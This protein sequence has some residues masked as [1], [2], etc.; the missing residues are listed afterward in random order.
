MWVHHYL[1]TIYK[2]D[3]NND[4]AILFLYHLK[5]DLHLQ[6]EQNSDALLILNR[7]KKKVLA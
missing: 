2:F 3:E 6:Y 5:D 1:L 4:T 7:Y